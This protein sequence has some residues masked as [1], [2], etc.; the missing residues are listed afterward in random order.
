M[1]DA[2]VPAPDEEERSL[3]ATLVRLGIARGDEAVELRPLTGGV[4]SDIRLAL[5][6]AGPVV[7]KRALEQLKVSAVWRAPRSRVG[8]EAAW[9]QYAGSVVPRSCPQVI[10][11]EAD[12]YTM[13][14]EYLEPA[15]H[16]NW[17]AELLAGHIDASFA[18]ALGDNLGRIH[19]ASTVEPDLAAHFDNGE[20]FETLRVEPYLVRA[21]VAVPQVGEALHAIAAD[22]RASRIALVHGDVS[23]KNILAAERPVFLDAECATWGDPAFDAAFCL[24]HL[25]L[26]R[27][28]LPQHA[29][30]LRA[31]AMSYRSAYL[32]RVDWEAA[33]GVAARID[34]LVPALLLARVVGASPVDYLSDVERGTVREL[35]VAALT[36]DRSLAAS[37]DA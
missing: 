27:I 3:A 24:T 16:P 1:T 31:A 5:T 17:K 12:T 19:S 22:L 23:P 2:F 11:Y 8:S 7:V 37:L 14:L 35:A 18:A 30:A 26:K 28:H 6:E 33:D 20:L 15:S 32:A 13:V 21:A 4:S 25:V 29:A 36:G 34:R 9:L 10:A